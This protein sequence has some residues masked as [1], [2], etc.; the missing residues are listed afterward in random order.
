MRIEEALVSLRPGAVW[1]LNCTEYE[2]LEWL[3]PPT[4]EGGQE[5]PTKEEVEVEIKRL[6]Q[7]WKNTE[8]QRLRKQEYPDFGEYL[9]AFVKDDNLQMEAYIDKCLKVKAKYPKPE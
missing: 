8:Y 3:E 1:R 7:E 6:Q 5:K 9:D 2:C 4:T